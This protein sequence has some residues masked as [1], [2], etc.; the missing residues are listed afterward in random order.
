M[1]RRKTTD[2]SLQN[3]QRLCREALVT[4]PV[5]IR[6][7]S[8]VFPIDGERELVNTPPLSNKRMCLVRP[9]IAPLCSRLRRLFGLPVFGA[10]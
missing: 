10:R 1:F 8:E 3:L 2:V 6:V 5:V 4:D 7:L 9:F